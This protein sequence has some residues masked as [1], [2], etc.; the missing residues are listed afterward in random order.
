[1]KI[2][3]LV[4][5]AILL[6][7]LVIGYLQFSLIE[8][9][10]IIQQKN[11]VFPYQLNDKKLR[12]EMTEPVIEIDITNET[13][14][15]VRK[16][17]QTE[18]GKL[19][20]KKVY[21]DVATL[22]QKPELPNGC[23]IVSLTAVLNYYG[24]DISKT[25]MSDEYLPKQSFAI[26]NGKLYGSDPYKAYSGNPRDLK[27][28]FFSYAP[29]IIE[30]GKSYFENV[31]GKHSIEDISGSSREEIMQYLDQGIPVVVWTTLDLSKPKIK[32]GWYLNETNEYFNAPVNLH[33]VV[34][35]GYEGNM[36][37]VM[38]PLEGQITYNADTFFKSYEEMGK[39]ALVVN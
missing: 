37:H 8:D 28:A 15:H 27:G 24:Y 7:L 36:V 33:V 12:V 39:H 32:Y 29:P 34:L 6:C 19:E 38:N 1:M 16:V 26:K 10:Y 3:K 21:I 20:I 31:G 22:M 17:E 9:T 30:A 14:E 5:I 25:T 2:Q 18:E 13:L 11:V 23:E 35:N 4:L